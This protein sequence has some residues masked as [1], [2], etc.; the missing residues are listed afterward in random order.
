MQKISEETKLQ[1]I[2]LRKAGETYDSISQQLNISKGSISSICKEA[3]I[4]RTCIELTPEKIEEC[5]RLYDELGNIKKVAKESGISY[6]RLRNVIK[7][8]TI[9][10]KS[11]YENVKAHRRRVKE[12][13]VE[14]KGGE[15]QI[16]HYNKCIAALDFHHLDPT[17]KDFAISNS[18][19]YRN[20]DVL[21]AEVNKCI[22]VCA[23]C[24]R[25]LHYKEE[26]N[27]VKE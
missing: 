4:S 26:N 17:Q 15:C 7:S 27:V 12:L 21:K 13:L 25:E 9:T 19:I 5:Q 24:H 8:K 2:S 6:E 23:N 3:G 14:Y 16:C 11:S 20:I 22:L 10:P 18:N 1:V